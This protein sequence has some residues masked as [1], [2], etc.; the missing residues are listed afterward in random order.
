M[1]RHINRMI[2]NALER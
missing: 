2:Y 1:T